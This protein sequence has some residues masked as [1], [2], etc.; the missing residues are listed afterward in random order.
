MK[1]SFVE[2]V[3]G[4]SSAVSLRSS[5]FSLNEI[6]DFYVS[7][8]LGELSDIKKAPKGLC[9]ADGERFELPEGLPSTVFKT[10]AI[11]HSATHP[12]E[13]YFIIYEKK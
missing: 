9:L 7:P 1:S 2:I 10:V 8:S 5:K 4:G 3:L 12:C 6:L 13:N 11:D